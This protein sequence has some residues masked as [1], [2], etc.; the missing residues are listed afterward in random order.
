MRCEGAHS[1]LLSENTCFSNGERKQ[2]NEGAHDRRK[3]QE[4]L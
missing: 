2:N 4:E 3:T 1:V